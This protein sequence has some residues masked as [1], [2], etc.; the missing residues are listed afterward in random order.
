MHSVLC[1]YAC[2][3]KYIH[4]YVCMQTEKKKWPRSLHH[5]V[6]ECHLL[7]LVYLVTGFYNVLGFP[8]VFKINDFS[9]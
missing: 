7:D 1:V 3:Y 4:L 2:K 6:Q 5:T 8:K 9:Y